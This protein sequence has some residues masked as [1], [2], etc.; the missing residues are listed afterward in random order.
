[1]AGKVLPTLDQPA[2]LKSFQRANEVGHAFTK[3][4]EQLVATDEVAICPDD[5]TAIK[6]RKQFLAERI[7]P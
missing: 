2:L 7:L 4:Y 1:M 6:T 3:T 5:A